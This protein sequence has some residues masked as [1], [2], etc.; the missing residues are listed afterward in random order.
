M[1]KGG[2]VNLYEFV[3]NN[4]IEQIHPEGKNPYFIVKGILYMLKDQFV[5]YDSL[6]QMKG[7]EINDKY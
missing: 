5:P 7:I 1:G 3:R 4:P 6:K 2:R